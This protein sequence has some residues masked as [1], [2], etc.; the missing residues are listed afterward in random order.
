MIYFIV[1]LCSFILEMVIWWLSPEAINSRKRIRPE[2]ATTC[3]SRPTTDL[4]RQQ[5]R[6]DSN[7]WSWLTSAESHVHHWWTYVTLRDRLEII[8]LRP[9]DV[10]NSIWLAYLVCAQTFG[11]DQNC[12]CMSSS[13]GP[14]PVSYSSSNRYNHLLRSQLMDYQGYVDFQI[15][16][17]YHGR[18][19][20]PVYPFSNRNTTLSPETRCTVLLG[21]RHGLVRDDN[22]CSDSLHHV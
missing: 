2:G 15:Y 16:N 14:N 5:D 1:A 20:P 11:A 4:E 17:Y 3:L 22:G 12:D 7:R 10:A 13:W 9:C 18:G 8:F 6:E 21:F 19:E